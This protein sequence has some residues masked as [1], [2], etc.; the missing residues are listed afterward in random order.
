MSGRQVRGG[1][2]KKGCGGRE[3]VKERVTGREKGRREEREINR[4]KGR[5]KDTGRQE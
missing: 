4:K 3:R 1:G 5:K 2:R